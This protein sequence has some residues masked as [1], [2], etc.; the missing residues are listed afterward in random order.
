MKLKS[1]DL[2]TYKQSLEDVEDL[3]EHIKDR[4]NRIIVLIHKI[5]ETKSPISWKYSNVYEHN[6]TSVN[7]YLPCF[8]DEVVSYNATYFDYTTNAHSILCTDAYDYNGR[9]PYTFLWRNHRSYRV[10]N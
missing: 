8:N 6:N 2:E 7:D 1:S 4:V 9:F 3:A 10:A 5:F